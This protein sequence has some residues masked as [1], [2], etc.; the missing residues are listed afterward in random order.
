MELLLKR[1]TRTQESTIGE[2]SINGIFE[3]Y[4]L[5]DKDRG[6]NQGMTLSELANLKVHGQTCIP[7]GRYEIG[8]TFSNKF[9]KYLPLLMDVP[10]FA[11]IRIHAGNTPENTEGCLLPG[12]T[13]EANFVGNSRVAFNAL[14]AKIKAASRVEKV[15]ITIK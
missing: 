7:A 14:F 9:N 8:I 3:C 4:I 13:K 5:E 15:F 6:L 1:T 12:Q 11:G 10:A 2:L